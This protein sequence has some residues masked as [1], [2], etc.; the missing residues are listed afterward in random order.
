MLLVLV[1]A[2]LR[3]WVWGGQQYWSLVPTG[4]KDFGSWVQGWHFW[5]EWDVILFTEA[6]SAAPGDRVECWYIWFQ[7]FPGYLWVVS[8]VFL[9]Q[10]VGWQGCTVFGGWLVHAGFVLAKP[11]LEVFSKTH[12]CLGIPPTLRGDGGLVYHPGLVAGSRHR[13]VFL[14]GLLAVTAW[15]WGGLV[16]SSFSEY[17]WVFWCKIL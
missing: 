14:L 3:F 9:I 13:A 4:G 17:F 15:G 8:T 2:T 12:V 7:K 16:S 11:A 5:V 10:K 1:S 6:E